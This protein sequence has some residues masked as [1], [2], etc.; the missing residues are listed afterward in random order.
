M[1]NEELLQ[2]ANEV[3]TSVVGN[4]SGGILK[5]AQANRFLD[6]VIDQSVLMQQSRVVRMNNPSLEIDKLSVGTRLLAKATEATDTGANAAVTFA[7]VAL[8]TVKL[9]LDWEVST[10]SLED[11]IA[12][13]SLE[14]HIAQVMARQ[15]SNDMD[16]LLINGDTTSSNALLK[17]QDGFVKLGTANGVT[18]ATETNISRA[19]YDAILRKMPNKYLQRRNELRYFSGPGIVQDTIYTLQNPN[20][21]TEATAGAPSPGSTMGDR[22]YTNPGAPNGGP[23]SS[24]LAPFGIPLVEVPLMPETVAGSYTGA[25]GNHGYI[26]LTFPNNHIVG[27]QREITVYREFKPKKD[28]IEYTQFNRVAQNIENAAAYVICKDTKLRT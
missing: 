6:F 10:E 8:T 22:L 2:K 19:V 5:P 20:S 9:R 15:T 1:A 11:N 16:D 27:I 7:K 28:T 26:I 17:A 21:A 25:T 24:G 13:D 14:D 3:T 4:A 18:H 12:G 23:G